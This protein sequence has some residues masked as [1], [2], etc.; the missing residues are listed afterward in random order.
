MVVALAAK[1]EPGEVCMDSGAVGET[2]PGGDSG[3]AGVA[4]DYLGACL[5]VGE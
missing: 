1:S 3:L 5:V 4:L 2:E